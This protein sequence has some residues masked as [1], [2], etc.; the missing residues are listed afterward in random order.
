MTDQDKKS[1]LA[2]ELGKI[3]QSFM[4]RKL[5][6]EF[7]VENVAGLIE[8]R[9]GFLFIEGTQ[10]Q[11]WL[12]SIAGALPGE[13]ASETR[14]MAQRVYEKGQPVRQDRA[15]YVPMI[16]RNAQIG[17]I[18][19][20]RRE[21]DPAFTVEE[22][23]LASNLTFQM[24]SALKNL[25]LFEQ[26]L[27]MERLSAIGQTVGM[28][29]HE[30]KNIVQ[31]ATFSQEFL[32]MGLERKKEEFVAKGVKGI[33]KAIREMDGFAYEM[34]SLTKDY[35]ISPE[36]IQIGELLQELQ[37]D[38]QEKAAQFQIRLECMVENGLPGMEGEPRSLYRALLNLVK[39][40][41]EAADEKKQNRFVRVRAR[42]VNQDYYQILIEDNGVGMNDEVKARIFQAFFST[43][44]QKG[45]GLGLMI[46]DRTIK[47]HHGTVE[48]QSQLG[49]G[50][51]FALTL[52][53]K[54]P[55]G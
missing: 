18:C 35:K 2:Y 53:T 24:A 14:Q 15:L 1:Q 49:E 30:V 3:Y 7:F 5:L 54:I 28:V 26:N 8:A 33:A 32:R 43:K 11:L 42:P 10:N 4:D 29:L 38:L 41:F 39:N 50:T 44:G 17:L 40:A 52:P 31:L 23:A 27:K 12:E 34:L 47:A 45:T 48:V 36:P 22:Y 25:L 51:T 55:A 37:L 19:F 6:C 16:V 20:T 9:Q 13:V 46:I 21:S